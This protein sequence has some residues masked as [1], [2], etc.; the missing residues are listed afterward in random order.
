MSRLPFEFFLALRY[1][2]PK[3][4]FV[5]VITLISVIGVMLGVAVLIIVISVMTGFDQQLREKILGFGAHLRVF[6][7]DGPMEDFPTVLNTV[8]SNAHVQSAAPFILAQ[9]MVKTQPAAGK[10]MFAAPL[11]RGIDPSLERNV[12]NLSSNIILG[13]FNVS[14]ESVLVGVELAR[15]LQ[16]DVGDRIS[17]YSPQHLEE[18]ERQRGTEEEV[19]V[20]PDEFTVRGIFDVGYNEFNANVLITSL[21][22][23]QRLYDMPG[24]ANGLFVF[25]RDPLQAEEVRRELHRKLGPNYTIRLWT[26]E[27]NAYLT[28]IAVEKN[29]MFFILI[30]IVI[31]AAFSIMNSQITFV[32]QKTREIGMLKALGGTKE[33]VMLL[34]LS[35]SFVVGI[36]GVTT[37]LGLGWL[38][39]TYRNPFL[40]FLRRATGLEIFPASIYGFSELPALIDPRDVAV[41]CG[42]ALV[43]CVLAGLAPAWNAGRLKPVEALR[44]E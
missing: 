10:P 9:V 23:A 12:S 24:K 38:A 19:V 27:N 36:V 32:V 30:F 2:R 34:F 37:G 1:L 3:R 21:R 41:I 40:H 31:V 18:M 13:E 39:L 29:V 8:S 5:S 25:I 4:T 44:H 7:Y 15:H 42:T 33:Q 6:Q 22:N 16:L 43:I 11:V 17:I 14:R 20:L 28:A 26:E 35:Q